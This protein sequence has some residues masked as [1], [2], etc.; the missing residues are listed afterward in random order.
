MSAQSRTA[1]NSPFRFGAIYLPNGVWPDF[2]HPDQ[3]GKDFEF[4]QVMKPLEPFRE[5]LVTVSQMRT[6][7]VSLHLGASACWLNGVGPGGNSVAEGRGDFYGKISSKKTVDQF[8]ADKWAADTP[9]R[10]VE[11][12]TEDMGTAAGACDGFA[13]AHFNTLSWRDDTSPLPVGINPRVTFERL[14][15]DAGS[16]QQRLAGIKAKQ[17]LLDSVVNET[18]KLQK[19]LGATDKAI[20]DEYLT[21]VRRVEQQ[22]V[23]M[24]A[25]V[26]SLPEGADAPVGI[27]EVFDDHMTVTYD[28]LHLGYQADLTRVFTFL[29]GHEASTRSYAHIGVPEAHHSISHHGGNPDNLVKYGKIG[30][31]HVLKFAEFLQKCK[32]TKEGDGTLL[33]HMLVLWGSGMSNGNAHDRQNVPAVLVGG[34]NGR[35]EGNRHIAAAKDTPQANLLLG[36]AHV[37]GVEV[38]KMGPSTGKIEL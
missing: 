29:L 35:M 2:W 24:E 22:L 13:C 9:L 33:D 28:I 11:V 32:D 36:I 19:S 18:V 16:S 6:P 23:R 27:P 17:S 21:N 5:Q 12:G 26:A 38:E 8:I 30:T 14:F 7:F 34:A 25:R 10:S 20:L 15:G 1:A 3:A 31:Y 37:A 4:K